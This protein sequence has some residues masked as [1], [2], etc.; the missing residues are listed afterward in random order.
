[1]ADLP[2]PKLHALRDFVAMADAHSVRGAARALGL[3]QPA[4]TRSLRELEKAVGQPLFLRHARGVVLTPAG[5]RFLVRARSVLAE[6]R[7]GVDELQ[8]L[9]GELEG[10]VTVGLS[11]APILGLLPRSY[12]QFRRLC[13]RVR[14]RLQ[15][16]TFPTAEPALRDGRLDFFVGPRPERPPGRAYR[17]QM[18]FTNQ[19]MVFA[20]RGHPLQRARRLA[21]L[22][23][24][25]WIYSGLREK[26][27]QDLEDLF[28]AHGLKPPLAV[29][30][31]DSLLAMLTLLAHSDALGAACRANGPKPRRWPPRSGRCRWT[32]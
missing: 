2:M 3:A 14:L 20:R 11:S 13:P 6:L 5:E 29:T 15:E 27:E 10:T 23:Q 19:R 9:D 12:A 30:R 32:R 22:A 16:A 8:Q 1:M 18:L 4:V 7:R 26:A 24:A 25:D 31:V 21:E 28:R 17:V